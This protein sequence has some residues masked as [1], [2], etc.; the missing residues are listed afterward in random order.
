MAAS[1]GWGS[2]RSVF[3]ALALG[4][5]AIGLA[6]RLPLLP[7]LDVST[8]AT[9]PI[10]ASLKVQGGHGPFFTDTPRFGYGRTLSYLPLTLPPVDGLEGYGWRRIVVQS[11][12][13]P[14][15]FLAVLLA[16]PGERAAHSVPGAVLAGL[17]V[18]TDPEL[19]LNLLWGHHGYLGP[20]WSALAL[21]AFVWMLTDSDRRR[22]GPV[23]LGAALAFGAMNHPYALSLFAVLGVLFFFRGRLRSEASP[24]TPSPVL[25][26]A[27]AGL[28]LSP[29]VLYLLRLPAG[30]FQGDVLESLA[31]STPGSDGGLLAALS[32]LFGQVAPVYGVVGLLGLL[33]CLG[34]L[35]RRTRRSAEE[36]AARFGLACM[37]TV[38]VLVALSAASRQVHNWH[39][40]HLVPWIA[41]C[42]GLAVAVLL[43]RALDRSSGSA[44][45][46]L[47]G[48]GLGLLCCGSLMA[49]PVGVAAYRSP[50]QEAQNSLLQ[51]GPVS[52]LAGKMEP[53]LAPW[54]LVGYLQLASERS[55][56]GARADLFP[57]V[58]DRVLAGQEQVMAA[59]RDALASARTLVYVEGD[60]DWVSA[61]E[62]ELLAAGPMGDLDGVRVIPWARSTP[63]PESLVVLADQPRAAWR[64]GRTI[65]RLS[66]A[67]R[68]AYD[69]PRD[70]MALLGAPDWSEQP[71][72]GLYPCGDQQQ[73]PT[74]P[75]GLD[76]VPGRSTPD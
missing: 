48:A 39:A 17:V 28:A 70:G 25:A 14:L 69:D 35:L 36:L 63:Y 5:F 51:L 57:L 26:A 23:L 8:D 6:L 64:L 4:L 59:D 75:A 16:L 37:A 15:V 45:R 38:C 50:L 56:A 55:G 52:E 34:Q 66:G 13:A 67:G 19:L 62:Q 76:A 71:G 22:R 30:R 9:D 46:G 27:I 72:P 29:H 74:Q 2:R 44:Q 73:P 65:C 1:P 47:A 21:L 68:I 53:G 3:L 58:L 43:R 32:G 31:A 60:S 20:E 54:G 61:V 40:R 49:V 42:L 41:C 12:V 11:L 24:T 33:L 18:A 7:L 10:V